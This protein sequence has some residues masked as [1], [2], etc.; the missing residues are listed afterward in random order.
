MRCRFRVAAA[1]RRSEP[2]ARDCPYLPPGRGSHRYR[3]SRAVEV[4]LA[5]AKAEVRI[6]GLLIR[7]AG[8]AA[9][10]GVAVLV[11]RARREVGRAREGDRQQLLRGPDLGRPRRLRTGPRRRHGTTRPASRA[12]R[13]ARRRPHASSTRIAASPHQH[14]VRS[15]KRRRAVLLPAAER[16][17]LIHR[18][19]SRGVRGANGAGARGAAGWQ[20]IGA[21]VRDRRERGGHRAGRRGRVRSVTFTQ[22]EPGSL[23]P[24]QFAGRPVRSWLP[25]IRPSGVAHEPEE[26]VARALVDEVT[27]YGLSRDRDPDLVIRS[28][29]H[30]RVRRPRSGCWP[31]S[32]SDRRR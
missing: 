8:S 16:L 11:V 30:A 19:A 24:G 20:G 25:G 7:L 26:H 27:I 1:K 21:R 5:P 9:G 6:E 2:A 12:S 4:D 15:R 18:A 31:A 3:P 23:E 28:S 14:R 29:G 32:Q 17:V 13:P 10:V 22:A